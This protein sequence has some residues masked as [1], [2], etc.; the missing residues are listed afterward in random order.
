[1]ITDQH[2]SSQHKCA[3]ELCLRQKEQRKLKKQRLLA[4]G[5]SEEEVQLQTTW[6]NL[7][8]LEYLKTSIEQYTKYVI[9]P[10]AD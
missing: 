10:W 1:M 2:Y 3:K 6:K 5:K 8:Y 7:D 9:V 4:E